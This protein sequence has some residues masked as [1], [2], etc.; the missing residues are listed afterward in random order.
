MLYLYDSFFSF[1]FIFD[2]NVFFCSFL[3]FVPI[4]N[5]WY[6]S[7]FLTVLFLTIFSLMFFSNYFSGLSYFFGIDY[8]SYSLILLSFLIVSLMVLSMVNLFANS[9]F[10]FLVFLLFICLV[11]FFCVLNFFLMYMFFEFSL[12][13]LLILI[14]GW[15]YQPE[16]LLAGFY[17]FFYTLF[18]SLPF[19]VL[20]IFFYLSIGSSFFDMFNGYSCSFFVYFF[21]FFSFLIKLPMFIF[22][23]WLPKAHVQAPICGSMILAGIML[24]VGGYGIIRFMYFYEYTFMSY[25]FIFYSFSILGSVLVGLICFVQCDIKCMIAYSSI[26]HMM[27][28]LL[29]ILSMTTWGLFGCYLMMVAHGFCSSGL[30]CLS[31]ISYS[32]LLSRSFYLNKGLINYFP[33]VTFFWFVFCCFNMSCPPSINFLSELFILFSM[34]NYFGFSYFFFFFISF[35]SSCFSFYLFSYSQHGIY[36]SNYSFS[37]VNVLEFLLLFIHLVPIFFILFVINFMM[38]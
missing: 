9:F 5:F 26:S 14:F 34:I 22:H 20:I 8:I 36:F 31:S 17:L 25:S 32:R 30:F 23:F 6:L 35:F 28:G 4:F 1:F 29:G 33:S 7:Q 15:G 3:V 18:S 38:F 24:K 2:P 27:L 16:R 13:P 10:L 11:F 19:L 12:I 21:M 37:C